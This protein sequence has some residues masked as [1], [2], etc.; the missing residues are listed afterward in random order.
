MWRIALLAM[1]LYPGAAL[2][3]QAAFQPKCNV[4]SEANDS[5]Q[6]L[7]RFQARYYWTDTWDQ[8]LS[9]RTDFII[10]GNRTY[11]RYPTSG[12]WI[13]TPRS[14]RSNPRKDCR[15]LGAAKEGGLATQTWKFTLLR[16]DRDLVFDCVIVLEAKSRLPLDRHCVSM[17][18]G[19]IRTTQVWTYR[20]D[21][22]APIVFEARARARLGAGVV[23][24]DEVRFRRKKVQG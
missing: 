19:Q 3:G 24:N 1:V 20:A 22:L 23:A 8:A 16:P 15:L 17:P 4:L 5:L 2:A 21:A 18:K 9:D 14:D 13:S 6:S 11:Q 7:S 12:G 10:D